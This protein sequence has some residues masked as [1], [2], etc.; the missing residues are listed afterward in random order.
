VR[1]KKSVCC[2]TDQHTPKQLPTATKVC[3]SK[4]GEC[5]QRYAECNHIQV[6]ST[7]QVCPVKGT[8]VC[9]QALT[10]QISVA[11]ILSVGNSS[12]VA[13]STLTSEINFCQ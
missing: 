13:I 10:K 11:P 12:L 8:N 1:V 9:D 2:C 6:S 5:V 3:E 7:K 4:V